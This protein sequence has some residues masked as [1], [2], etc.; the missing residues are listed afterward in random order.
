MLYCVHEGLI[1]IITSNREIGIRQVVIINQAE[2]AQLFI[3]Q[4]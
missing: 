2:K 4:F 1:T 3:N